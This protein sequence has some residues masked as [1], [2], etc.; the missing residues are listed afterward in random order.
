VLRITG[1]LAR[2]CGPK[3]RGDENDLKNGK[4]TWIVGQLR[5]MT[6]ELLLGETR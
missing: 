6:G 4:K 3:D 2:Y 1:E 5:A